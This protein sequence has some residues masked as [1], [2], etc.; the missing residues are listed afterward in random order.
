MGALMQDLRFA[1]RMFC[2]NPGFTVVA[3]LTLA[4]GIG[5]NTAMFSLIDA[6]LL[7]EL[8]VHNP[9]ELVFPAVTVA[10]AS[11]PISHFDYPAFTDLRDSHALAALCGVSSKPMGL[12]VNGQGELG[13][14]QW[15][16]G[17]YY[18]VLGIRP[19]LGRLLDESD[20]ALSGGRAVA[21][22]SHRFWKRRLGGDPGAVGRLIGVNGQPFEIVGVE[23]D[24]FDG[25]EF[26][27][28]TD[29]TIPATTLTR[30]IPSGDL[31]ERGPWLMLLG[32]L[33]PGVT[34][35]RAKAE[36]ATVLGRSLQ[37]AIAV[38]PG[39]RDSGYANPVF[40][41]P[42]NHGHIGLRE[43]YERPVMII[44]AAA[45]LILLITCVNLANLLL[46][47]TSARK[48]EMAVRLS[49]GAGRPRLIR[50]LL[51]ESV[52]LSLAGGI[53]GTLFASWGADVL[54]AFLPQE[55]MAS[56]QVPMD[57]RV[58]AFVLGISCLTGIVFG[59]APAL[60]GTK[61]EVWSNLKDAA[62]NLS[63]GRTRMR[64]TLV[65]AQVALTLVLL[66]GSSLVIRSLRNLKEV[67]PGFN[68]DGVLL[69]ALETLLEGYKPEQIKRLFA[70]LPEHIQTLPG[71]ESVG[72]SFDTLLGYEHMICGVALAGEDPKGPQAK[73]LHANYAS[74]GFFRTVGTPLLAGRDFDTRDN[75]RA[76]HVAVINRAAAHELYSADTPLGQR[77]RTDIFEGDWEVIGVVADAK[78]NSLRES[79]TPTVYLPFD[80][81]PWIVHFRTLYLRSR[82]DP[83][84]LIPAVRR[85]I[86]SVAKGVPLK[87]QSLSAQLDVSLGTERMVSTIAGFFS[88]M[89]LLLACVGLYGITAFMVISRTREIGIRLALGAEPNHVIRM[90]VRQTFNLVAVGVAVGIPIAVALSSL[91]SA[92][93]YG[94]RA[95]AVGAFVGPI[96]AIVLAMAAAACIP[97]YRAARIDPAVAL[98]HE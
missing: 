45:G 82:G 23:P 64:Q 75:E 32:R 43:D 53:L 67:N 71:V 90:V 5:A 72:L 70:E 11:V 1:L 93:L 15:A 4:L 96:L 78:Y 21:V 98:R 37:Q 59:I 28:P 17:S 33:K 40:L 41:V 57:F 18:S 3:V 14:G 66:T 74:P 89:A 61:F 62:R 48:Q 13:I 83:T 29:V 24:G 88:V 31:M 26:G 7:K 76:P 9:G 94:V 79:S 73:H 86:N 63:P 92:L 50:Q 20:E 81:L 39:L 87:I 54:L 91:V 16:T 84:A 58:L 19:Y 55:Y 51:T 77:F 97:V 69:A 36:V 22:V 34:M 52:L 47:R 12:N 49:I 60:Q 2:K 56:I 6:A 35:E 80:Q 8:P 30:L 46:A 85:E 27:F 38:N 10:W 68:P 42:G 65:V 25:I 44:S 95:T